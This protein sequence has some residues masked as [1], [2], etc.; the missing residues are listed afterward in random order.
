[1]LLITFSCESQQQYSTSPPGYDLNN[2]KRYKMPSVLREISGIAF[3]HGYPDTLYAEQDEEGKVFHFKLGDDKLQTTRFGKKGDF[4]D[5]SICNKYVIML[6]SDGVL[7]TFPFSDTDLPE[8]I[9]VKIFNGL[10]PAGE[11]E[12]LASIDSGGKIF[13]LCKHCMEDKTSR[14]GGGFIFQLNASGD[15][16]PAGSF[17]INVREI[18]TLDKI[19]KINFHPSGLSWNQNTR[20]WYILSSVNKLLVIA[21]EDWKIKSVYQLNPS[22]FPQPEGIAFDRQQ[23]LYISNEKNLTPAAT[24][25]V[26]AYQ[27]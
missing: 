15:L 8:A 7:F 5:I 23:N 12:G 25:L 1:M 10:L 11:Y 17:E 4:E 21:N 18:E 9:H 26:F 13:V 19:R 14:R 3:D 2:P 24:V 6:R 22:V 20:E 27:R 16:T